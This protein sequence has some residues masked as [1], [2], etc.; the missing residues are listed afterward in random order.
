MEWWIFLSLE[1]LFNKRL[2][3]TVIKKVN[4][5]IVDKWNKNGIVFV[6]NGNISNMDLYQDGLHLLESGKCLLANNFIFL[7]NNFL[8]MHSHHPF[9]SVQKLPFPE[10]NGFVWTSIG[11]QT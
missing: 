10:G 1:S 2:P 3:Y 11:H 7:S 8:S 4:E 9:Q 5:N 6:D